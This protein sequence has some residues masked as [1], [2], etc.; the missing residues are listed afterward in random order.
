MSQ[1]THPAIRNATRHAATLAHPTPR[2]RA[3]GAGLVQL[4]PLA[5]AMAGAAL[6]FWYQTLGL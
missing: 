1:A 2:W 5:L 6:P 3:V 4:A